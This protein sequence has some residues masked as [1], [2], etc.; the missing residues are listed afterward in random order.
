[1]L[2]VR[3]SSTSGREDDVRSTQFPRRREECVSDKQTVKIPNFPFA[4]LVVSRPHKQAST[5]SL[6][7]KK[8]PGGAGT[9]RTHTGHEGAQDSYRYC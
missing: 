1:M 4:A 2:R 8:T 9:H 6:N 7:R 5:V 3:F